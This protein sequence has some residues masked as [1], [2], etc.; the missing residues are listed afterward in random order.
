MGVTKRVGYCRMVGRREDIPRLWFRAARLRMKLGRRQKAAHTQEF[1]MV[2][3][4]EVP[5]TMV[6]RR[7]IFPINVGPDAAQHKRTALIFQEFQP[8]HTTRHGPVFRLMLSAATALI[9]DIM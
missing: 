2:P 3:L 8:G 7:N 6:L 4:P 5:S 9:T 1:C